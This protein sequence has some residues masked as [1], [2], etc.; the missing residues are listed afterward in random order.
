MKKSYQLDTTLM[1][2]FTL[3]DAQFMFARGAENLNAPLLL[4]V[5]EIKIRQEYR[6]DFVCRFCIAKYEFWFKKKSSVTTGIQ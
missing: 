6:F 3:I 1:V 5:I 4:I 2:A